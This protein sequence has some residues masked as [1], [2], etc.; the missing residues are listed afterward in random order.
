MMC[1]RIVAVD[2]VLVPKRFL[3]RRGDR[4]DDGLGIARG[5]H[6][7]LRAQLGA[8]AIAGDNFGSRYG[9]KGKF[10]YG[11]DRV[12]KTGDG[13]IIVDRCVVGVSMQP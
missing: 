13:Q 11:I 12:S 9:R 6:F 3:Q 8:E 2:R 4:L 7:D 10:N 5:S 1:A